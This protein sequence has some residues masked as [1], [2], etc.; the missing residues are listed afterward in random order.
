MS[1]SVS[2]VGDKRQFIEVNKFVLNRIILIFNII[3]HIQYCYYPHYRVA[4]G[5]MSEGRESTQGHGATAAAV[6]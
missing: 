1:Q 2:N 3:I 5:V 6:G 4:D